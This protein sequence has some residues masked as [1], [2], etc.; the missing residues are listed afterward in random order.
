MWDNRD[1]LCLYVQVIWGRLFKLTSSA[2][3]GTLYQLRNLIHRTNVPADPEKNMNS[4]EDFMLLMLHGH[5]VAAAKVVFARSHSTSSVQ[6]LAKKIIEDFAI[7]PQ[8]TNEQDDPKARKSKASTSK[9]STSIRDTSESGDPTRVPVDGVHLYAREV[10]SLGLI[11]HGFHDAIREGDGDRILSYWKF[12]LVLFKST[13]HRNYAKEAVNLLLQYHYTLSDRKKAQLK[14]SRCINTRGFPGANIPCDLH[15]EHLNRRLKSV[16]RGMGANVNSAAI[17]RAGKA[18]SGVHH[19]CQ[20]FEQQTSTNI[21]SDHHQVPTF[22]KDFD[23][24]LSVLQE[25]R[26][27]VPQSGR[28]HQSFKFNEGLMQ[29][30]SAQTL[31]KKVES[32]IKK[33]V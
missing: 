4:A 1:C 12:L 14:W 29:K 30:L 24:V 20:V 6:E 23:Q 31:R 28:Q 22:G 10:L 25:E 18:I 19:I 32:N 5:V 3:K 13:N 8:T 17:E 15:M 21:H 27:F 9:A 33:I 7:F 26:V 16:I 11:W 2:E